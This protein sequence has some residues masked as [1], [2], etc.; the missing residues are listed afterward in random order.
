MK[1]R[2]AVMALAGWIGAVANPLWAAEPVELSTRVSGV[3]ETVWVKPGQRVKKGSPLLRLD[4]TILQASLAEATAELTRAQAD[5]GEARR[6]RERAQELFNRTVSSTS[7]LD[8]AVL[9]DAR[10]QAGLAVAKARR[11]IAQ[12][13][14]QDAELKAP[15][16]GVVKAVPGGPGTVVTAECQ[17]KPLVIFSTA[18]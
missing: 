9:L 6:E 16:D 8:A 3:V 15:F 11:V 13:N 5:A 2:V 4:R 7:E 14:L 12:K 10:A 1:Q 18:P 17:P